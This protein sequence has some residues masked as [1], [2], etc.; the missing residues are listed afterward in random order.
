MMHKISLFADDVL[1]FIMNPVSS[2]P[3]LMQ[4]LRNFG[5]IS[6][7][8][9]NEGKSE[10]MMITGDRPRQ[11]DFR[12]L[13]VILAPNS[14]SLYKAYFDE[15]I[16]QIRK[17]LERQGLLPLSLVGRVET[18]RINVLPTML[19]LFCSL[20]ITVPV[21]TFKFLNRLISEFIW[22][23]K[24]PRLRLKVLHS[25]KEKGGL[26]LPHFRSYYWASQL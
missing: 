22:Q 16:S 6:G 12:S 11:L 4:C 23:N 25:D 15:L 18:I 3:A 17:D 5:E 14:S 10:A 21:S 1:L 8:K 20:P 7:Y 2:F 24:R 26:A 19:F 13:G 9:V